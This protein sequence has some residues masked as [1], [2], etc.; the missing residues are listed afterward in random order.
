M[1]NKYLILMFITLSR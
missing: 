1:G